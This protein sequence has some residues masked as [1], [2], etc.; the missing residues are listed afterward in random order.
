MMDNN[1]EKIDIDLSD[2]L[3]TPYRGLISTTL[4]GMEAGRFQDFI[5]KYLPIVDRKYL[6]LVPFGSTP[7]GKTT[8]GVPDSIKTLL[9]GEQVACECSTEEDYWTPPKD[10]SDYQAKWKPVGDALKCF[11]RVAKLK[12]IVLA[13]NRPIPKTHP[14]V[15]SDLIG[16]LQ[17]QKSVPVTPISCEDIAQWLVWN[18]NS[19]EARGLLRE[20]FPEVYRIVE[21]TEQK[22]KV[23]VI[24]DQLGLLGSPVSKV[25]EIVESNFGFSKDRLSAEIQNQLGF[26]SEKYQRR[27]G[28][29][30]GVSRVS[31]SPESLRSPLGKCT[32]LLGTPKIGKTFLCHEV[33]ETTGLQTD[34]Y[35]VPVDDRQHSEFL[36]SLV[37]GILSL[38]WNKSDAVSAYLEHSL[39]R[40]PGISI[41]APENKRVVV[42][43]NAHLLSDNAFACLTEAIEVIKKTNLMM[44]L[45]VVFITNKNI[46]LHFRTL[47]HTD[48][49]PLWVAADL[50]KLLDYVGIPIPQENTAKFGE[51]LQTTSLGHPLYAIALGKKYKTAADIV[52]ILVSTPDMKD[53]DLSNGLKQLL[54]ADILTTSDKQN[55]V[56]RLAL[57]TAPARPKVLECLRVGISPNIPASTQVIYDEVGG[58]VLDGDPESGL[59]VSPV[60]RQIAQGKV[61]DPEKV[62]V[63]RAVAD[64]LL[65]AEGKTIDGSAAIDAIYYLAFARDFDKAIG[66]AIRVLYGISKNKGNDAILKAVLGRLDLLTFINPPADGNVKIQLNSF[67]MMMAFYN[68]SVG[69][70]KQASRLLSKIDLETLDAIKI[71]TELS[72]L[73]HHMRTGVITQRLLLLSEE[74]NPALLLDLTAT[75]LNKATVEKPLLEI[76]KILPGLISKLTAP[77]LLTVN[78]KPLLDAIAKHHLPAVVEL[79]V[80][81]GNLSNIN[82]ELKKLVAQDSPP[83]TLIHLFQQVITAAAEAASGKFETAAAAISKI[84]MLGKSLGY[85][86]ERLGSVFMQLKGDVHFDLKDV[87]G[88]KSAYKLSNSLTTKYESHILGTN[89]FK[90]GILETKP[91]ESLKW[92]LSAANELEKIK[93]YNWASRALGA[94]AVVLLKKGDNLQAI[95]IGE[96]LTIWY[97]CE[98]RKCG[99][100]L[101]LLSSQMLAFSYAAK[102]EPI[103]EMLNTTR[104]LDSGLYLTVSSDLEPA[105]GGPIVFHAFS[106]LANVFKLRDK[107]IQLLKKSFSLPIR[108]KLD[109]NALFMHY[110]FLLMELEPNELN[111]EDIRSNL[112]VLAENPPMSGEQFEKEYYINLFIRLYFRLKADPEKWRKLYFDYLAMVDKVADSSKL[113]DN[114]L[115]RIYADYYKG[116]AFIECGEKRLAD[117]RLRAAFSGAKEVGLSDVIME[118]GG[119][120]GFE[121]I[122]FRASILELAEY[123]YETLKAMTSGSFTVTQIQNLGINLYRCWKGLQWRRLTSTDLEAN[124]YLCDSAKTLSESGLSEVDAGLIM[125]SLMQRL[126]KDSKFILPTI[127]SRI[128]ESIDKLLRQ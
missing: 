34:W 92:F 73:I 121:L 47:N 71:P 18:A 80:I 23:E 87:D 8:S 37:A 21:V 14:N 7:F 28:K 48:V 65:Q 60:F 1:S 57:L 96:R 84:E 59:S 45:G 62:A 117:I 99:A 104:S 50:L 74:V 61:S 110:A 123:Q 38:F 6:G 128:P 116:L 91:E 15:K 94:A 12:E 105:G 81:L 126:F 33:L 43:D 35:Q 109:I 29:F 69:N 30:K 119:K 10:E 120:L 31:V 58:A 46:A 56:Q 72:E 101:R 13:A 114:P 63:Y 41:V 78:Y 124:R 26:D 25:Q 55:F 66:W 90:L 100:A 9:S 86:V 44:N 4:Q 118:S 51:L 39:E 24:L 97:Y 113:K 127:S 82:N 11:S 98:N 83:E 115:Y 93:D 27:L 2:S 36:D 70:P 67:L 107:R 68:T 108:N 32:Q 20:F 49:A 125:V 40:L 16:Y 54:Y 103:P 5:V 19:S 95:E 77:Q 76:V 79:G 85:K 106:E 112:Q 89:Q 88:S 102:G 64:V 53:P 3:T 122:G 111:L 75:E 22:E 42:V 52:P 17:K